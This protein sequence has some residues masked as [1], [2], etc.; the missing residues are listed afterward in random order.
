MNG[1]AVATS[2]SILERLSEIPIG[3]IIAFITAMSVICVGGWKIISKMIKLYDGYK[4]LR[5]DRDQTKHQVERNSEAIV[6]MKNQFSGAISEVKGQLSI[7]MD[8]LNEQRDTKITE[9]RHSI[10]V[11]GESAL[12]N[13]EMTIREYTS[14]HEMVDKYLHV[15]NQ[16]WYVESLIKKVD[17][18]V[19]VIGELDEHGNDID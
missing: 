2:A 19:R 12:A 7:I 3:T 9:L 15:Y 10:V 18:D 14:L 5:E 11:A 17:R 16:N 4:S 8:A 6:E 13:G 1:E